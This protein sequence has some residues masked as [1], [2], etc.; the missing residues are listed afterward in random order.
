MEQLCIGFSGPDNQDKRHLQI[1]SCFSLVSPSSPSPVTQQMTAMSISQE[2]GAVD[3]D[4][5]EAEE[6]EEDTS[7]N[8]GKQYYLFVLFSVWILASSIICPKHMQL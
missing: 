6:G 1:T 8:A 3:S 7:K 5:A 2:S 4:R